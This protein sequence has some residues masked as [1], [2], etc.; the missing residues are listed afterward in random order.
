MDFSQL[1]SVELSEAEMIGYFS[2]KDSISCDLFIA[3]L[4]HMISFYFDGDSLP[5]S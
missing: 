3:G 2:C 1:A 5:Y 4:S